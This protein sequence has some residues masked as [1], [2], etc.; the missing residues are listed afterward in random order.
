MCTYFDQKIEKLKALLHLT[1]VAEKPRNQ[2][3]VFVD[4]N[5]EGQLMCFYVLNSVNN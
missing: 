3:V 5:K 4:S 1:D 2:H